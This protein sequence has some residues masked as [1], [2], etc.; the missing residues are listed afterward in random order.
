MK[1]LLITLL[2]AAVLFAAPAFE[3][4]RTFT[5]PDGSTFTGT[6]KGDEYLH[7]IETENGEI[8]VYD[9]AAK[10]YEE[11]IV[12]PETLKGSG[13]IYREKSRTRRARDL[14]SPQQEREALRQ[15]WLKKRQQEMQRRSGFKN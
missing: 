15:L 3:R 8:L 14:R 10:Q 2:S 4:K 12:T 13:R 5:Q 7:W 1:P 6:L 9:K 11:A